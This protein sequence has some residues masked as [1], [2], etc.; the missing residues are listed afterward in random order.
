MILLKSVFIIAIVAVAMIGMI[1]PSSFAQ[2]SKTTI[3]LDPIPSSIEVYDSIIVS[4]VLTSID[5]TPIP[6]TAV[7]IVSETDNEKSNPVNTITNSNGYFESVLNFN[8]KDDAGNWIVYSFF[9]GNEVFD[10]SYSDNQYL[11]VDPPTI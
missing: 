5:G 1:V 2:Q 8:F 11:N 6:N 10:F 3:T 7:W 4:G 9:E